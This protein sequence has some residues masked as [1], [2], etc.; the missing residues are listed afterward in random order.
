MEIELFLRFFFRN[1]INVFILYGLFLFFLFF[2]FSN[3]IKYIFIKFNDLFLIYILIVILSFIYALSMK[4]FHTNKYYSEIIGFSILITIILS[5]YS[6]NDIFLMIS[7]FT[8]FLVMFFNLIDIRKI[9]RKKSQK[10]KNLVLKV[11]TITFL[12]IVT[13][14][15]YFNNINSDSWKK[16]GEK[17]GGVNYLTFNLIFNKGLLLKNN[18]IIDVDFKKDYYKKESL[19]LSYKR[20]NNFEIDNSYYYLQLTNNIRL[21]V[22]DFKTENKI[23]FLLIEEKITQE[24]ISKYSLI[25]ISIIN[26]KLN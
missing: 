20:E 24:A 21:F 15:I 23:A 19:T 3:F 5:M 9:K 10:Q 12:M 18:S 14:Y 7:I 8:F 11:I 17:E 6:Y 2:L 1:R 13:L 22:K 4:L 26:K 16:I 25:D